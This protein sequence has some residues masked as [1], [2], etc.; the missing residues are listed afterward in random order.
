MLVLRHGFFLLSVAVTP[1]LQF[2]FLHFSHNF[3]L[4]AGYRPA[5]HAGPSSADS[6]LSYEQFLEVQLQELAMGQ[7][8]ELPG[9]SE[10][11]LVNDLVSD[12]V[13]EDEDEVQVEEDDQ[14]KPSV[15]APECPAPEGGPA[16]EGPAPEIE[17]NSKSTESNLKS[18]NTNT[19]SDLNVKTDPVEIDKILEV[20]RFIQRSKDMV[21]PEF[22]KWHRFVKPKPFR[23]RKD[24]KP[25]NGDDIVDRIREFY[26]DYFEDH[27]DVVTRCLASVPNS[28]TDVL[29]N[30]SAM[31]DGKS[32]VFL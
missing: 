2:L 25:A 19:S 13:L 9:D 21:R 26:D 10:D 30:C 18:E 16:P 12:I 14:P 17:N 23:F 15:P 6:T 5:P 8:S 3:F 1:L 4:V 27:S 24:F 20:E 31:S 32:L 7:A 11:N 29:P 22:E 28:N